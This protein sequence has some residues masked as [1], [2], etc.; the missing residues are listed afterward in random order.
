[1]RVSPRIPPPWARPSALPTTEQQPGNGSAP[2]L[3]LPG[4]PAVSPC[5]GKPFCSQIS[6]AGETV[7][8]GR[9]VSPCNCDTFLISRRSTKGRWPL[10][11]SA[12]GLP[13]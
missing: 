4:S 6:R 8:L 13:G 10:S 2:C 11:A 12:G 9:L 3:A 5:G 1:R 7:E